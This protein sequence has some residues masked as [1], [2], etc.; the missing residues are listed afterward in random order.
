MKNSEQTKILGG[1]IFV[2]GAGGILGQLVLLRE[3]MI[4]FYGNELTLGLI[5]ANWLLLEAAG[6]FI[7]SRISFKNAEYRY[8]LLMILY[9]LLLPLAIY[10]SRG[11]DNFLFVLIPGETASLFQL[12]FASFL[13]S[14]VSLIHG[15]LFPVSVELLKKHLREQNRS[16]AGT[17]YLR[18]I[19]GTL[20]GGVLFSLIL[21]NFFDSFQIVLA[22]SLLHLLGCFLLYRIFSVQTK[23]QIF[24]LSVFM[25]I[26][27]FISLLSFPF[28]RDFLHSNSLLQQFAEENII[29]YENTVYGNIVISYSRG[30]YT[31]YY[32]GRPLFTDPSYDKYQTA[33]FVHLTAVSHPDP[34]NVL[35]LG[36]GMGGIINELKKHRFKEIVYVELDGRLPQLGK[37]IPFTLVSKELDIEELIIEKKDARFY[38]N[39]T[40]KKFDLI[41]IGFLEPE[42]LQANRLFTVEFFSQ[43]K[44]KLT[45]TGVFAFTLPGSLSYLNPELVKYNSSLYYTV[46]DVFEYVETIPGDRNIFLSSNLP[47]SLQT[48]LM[49]KRLNDRGVEAGFIT[50]DYLNYKLAEERRQWLINTIKETKAE[51]NRDFKPTAFFQA[52]TYWGRAFAP[53]VEKYFTYLQELSF[54]KTVIILGGTGLLILLLFK[55]FIPGKDSRLIYAAGTT[56]MSG[57]AF[58]ILLLFVFQVLYGYVYQMM[59]FLVASFMGGMFLGAFLEP[60]FLKNKKDSLQIFKKFEFIIILL[61]AGFYGMAFLMQRFVMANNMFITVIFFAGYAL[62]TGITVGAEFPL[63]IISMSQ[64]NEVKKTGIIYGID[65]MGGWLAGILITLILFPVFGLGITLIF[66]VILK[67]ISLTLLIKIPERSI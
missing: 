49:A 13:L 22:V 66:L 63:A 58:D 44:D 12:F 20:T 27:L 39:K 4:T 54:L 62:I 28:L 1:I 30:E 34:E 5:L 55:I 67:I 32:D 10:L 51:I 31:V 42:T 57:M 3:L 29:H 38:L 18:E 21:V 8:K 26:F 11:I 17:V 33:D 59:G 50:V 6:S 19:A 35:I 47:I 56:G 52:L 40:D 53:R 2:T 37:E 25:V 60:Y 9:A 14:G 7:S 16:S 23:K 24:L 64:K 48:E 36:N 41:L 65:L 15:A 46:T 45:E 43:V 61:L